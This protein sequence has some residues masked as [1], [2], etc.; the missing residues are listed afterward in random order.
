MVSGNPFPL[1]TLAVGSKIPVFV[2]LKKNGPLS[3]T[4]GALPLV[5][6]RMIIFSI[7]KKRSFKKYLTGQNFEF[8]KTL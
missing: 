1:G 3:L 5:Q 7:N 4:N 6:V 8:C 2:R